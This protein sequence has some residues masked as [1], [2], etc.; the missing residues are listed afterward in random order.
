M[1]RVPAARA[2]E[3]SRRARRPES[4]REPSES[5][6]LQAEG[7]ASTTSFRFDSISFG[8]VQ[9]DWTVWFGRNSNGGGRKALVGLKLER[10]FYVLFPT[11]LRKPTWFWKAISRSLESSRKLAGALFARHARSLLARIKSRRASFIIAFVLREPFQ[12]VD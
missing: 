1:R 3:V 8:V 7:D 10:N 11:R 2:T 9:L 4:P 12:S 5:C 6:S